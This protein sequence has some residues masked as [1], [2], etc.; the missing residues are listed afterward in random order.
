M[1]KMENIHSGGE[2]MI[3][4]LVFDMAWVLFR[5]QPMRFTRQYISD[6]ADAEMVHREL[7]CAPEWLAT[8]RG[9]LSDEDYF[10][11]VS[12]RI[13][14]RLHTKARY[15]FEHWH[16]VLIPIR[17]MEPVIARLKENGYGIYLLTNMSRR[18]YRFCRDIPAMRYFD[19][20]VVSADE[21]CIKPEKEIYLALFRKY[22][23][24]PQECFFV[25]DRPENVKAGKR[26]GM[27][28]FCFRQDV[29]ALCDALR[30]AGVRL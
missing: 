6:E 21:H 29:P 10:T 1:P 4:N 13:P 15:L 25:D 3:R 16:E 28:G 5:Y 17:E 23:L 27:S 30:R 14:E 9:T 24:T 8:D 19:G 26:L 22:R 12:K 18:F 7:F 20:A 2:T 11:L